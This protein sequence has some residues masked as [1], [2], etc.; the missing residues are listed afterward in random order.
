MRFEEWLE[1]IEEL[2]GDS[3]AKTLENLYNYI[4]L[5][6]SSKI[7]EGTEGIVYY[8]TVLEGTASTDSVYAYQFVD[9]ITNTTSLDKTYQYISD[10]EIGQL[11]NDKSFIN[12]ISEYFGTEALN[13]SIWD[14]IDNSGIIIFQDGSSAIAI[15]DFFSY[16]YVNSLDCS[17]VTTLFSGSCVKGDSYNAFCR[18]EFEAI[19]DNNSIK[20][21]NGVD[22]VVFYDIYCSSPTRN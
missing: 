5:N 16:N 8:G 18:T 7:A 21:I 11:I 9:A 1:I 12:A 2:K 13:N 17:N 19:I 20:T 10:T 22:K 14:G 6:Y 4:S 15:N 3:D